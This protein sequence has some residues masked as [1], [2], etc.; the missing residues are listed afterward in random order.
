MLER[1]DLEPRVI[2]SV[3]VERVALL[4]GVVEAHLTRRSLPLPDEGLVALAFDVDDE[5]QHDVLAYLGEL[6]ELL[7]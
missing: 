6:D 2:V 1:G 4:R 5:G 7:G 3:D